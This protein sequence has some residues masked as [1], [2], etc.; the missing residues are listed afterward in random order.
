MK[1]ND[2]LITDNF[3]IGAAWSNK[4]DFKIKTPGT[5]TYNYSEAQINV[6]FIY[7][8][9]DFE[10]DDVFDVFY[11]L[12]NHSTF[13]TLFNTQVVNR[14][15]TNGT[16]KY[17]KLIADIMIIDSKP[18]PSIDD[19]FVKE[20]DFSYTHMEKWFNINPW[21]GETDDDGNRNYHYQRPVLKTYELESIGA[22]LE[23]KVT[24]RRQSTG[25]GTIETKL[26]ANPYYTLKMNEKISL[27]E[28]Y[29]LIYKISLLFNIFLGKK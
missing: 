28:F 21:I 29:K 8:E 15:C 13:I 18:I 14:K 24:P 19:F 4:S 17:I 6:E 7:P 2:K 9:F 11:G 10:F 1:L 23:E 5:L 3:T 25:V 27:K 12:I 22:V 26:S 20:V 16:I